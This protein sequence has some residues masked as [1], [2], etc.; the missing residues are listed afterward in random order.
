MGNRKRVADLSEKDF[1]RLKE[2]FDFVQ[3]ALD[4]IS[5]DV[6]SGMLDKRYSVEG[7]YYVLNKARHTTGEMLHRLETMVNIIEDSEMGRWKKEGKW[8]Q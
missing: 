4:S 7:T 8:V 5:K 2:C 3:I 1:E 6:H